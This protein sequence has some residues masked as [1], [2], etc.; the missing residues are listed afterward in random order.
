MLGVVVLS[1]LCDGVVRQMDLHVIGVVV[2]VLFDAESGETLRGEPNSQGF[3]ACNKHI[4]TDI[5]FLGPN[6]KW[7]VD[8]A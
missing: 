1:L 3:V 8:V 2:R 4:N 7:L 6:E 5:E